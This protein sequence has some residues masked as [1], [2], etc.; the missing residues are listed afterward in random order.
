MDDDCTAW[1][2]V[3]QAQVRRYNAGGQ[4]TGIAATTKCQTLVRIVADRWRSPRHS[5]RSIRQVAR[6]AGQGEWTPAVKKSVCIFKETRCRSVGSRWY[7][8]QFCAVY[9]KTHFP[10]CSVRCTRSIRRPHT[11]TQGRIKADAGSGGIFVFP[12]RVG[13]LHANCGRE[14]WCTLGETAF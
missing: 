10:S 1:S 2:R 14:A 6:L 3:Q 9:T 7:A 11:L 4:R 13:Q 8:I 12:T 5:S